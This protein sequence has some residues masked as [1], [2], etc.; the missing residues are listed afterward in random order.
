MTTFAFP[1][2][3]VSIHTVVAW[4]LVEVF[5]NVF[6]GLSRRWYVLW[7]YFALTAAF[8]IVF[9][10]YFFFFATFSA[11]VTMVIS[12]STLLIIEVII[13]RYMYSGELWFLNYTDWIVP[14][15]LAASTVYFT[16]MVQGF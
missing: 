6:H 14:L 10:F 16:G 2:V 9:S 3:I 11:F 4:L 8:V 12:I 13:F 1:L 7:H 15:F 5:V